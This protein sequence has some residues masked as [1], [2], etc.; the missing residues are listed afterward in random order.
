LVRQGHE[1]EAGAIGEGQDADLGGRWASQEGN[2]FADPGR[3]GDV[4]ALEAQ[5]ELGYE[6]PAAGSGE[7]LGEADDPWVVLASRVRS[8]DKHDAGAG[9]GAHD[10]PG[11]VEIRLAV[12]QVD[13][14][15]P[16]A[17]GDERKRVHRR[18][19]H[20][21]HEQQPFDV[22]PNRGTGQDRQETGDGDDSRK[23]NEHADRLA[24]KP[25]PDASESARGA[26]GRGV[27]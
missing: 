11:P 20:L 25:L 14:T 23:P 8:V 10:G 12:R 18:R 4:K 19:D 6:H 22:G 3:V 21:R 5:G 26:A 1:R 24:Q 9:A 27:S 15:P 7:G 13:Q 17:G 16:G 2:R